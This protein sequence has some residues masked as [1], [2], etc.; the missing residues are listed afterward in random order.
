ML[1]SRDVRVSLDER[2]EDLHDHLHDALVAQRARLGRVRRFVQR[3]ALLAHTSV[4]GVPVQEPGHRVRVLADHALPAV[5][6]IVALSTPCIQAERRSLAYTQLLCG[7]D[8]LHA[9][10]QAHMTHQ[11]L[12]VSQLYAATQQAC[13]A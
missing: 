7:N 13:A 5:I 10:F 4:Q 1:L 8:H 3:R 2:S 12:P 6:I 11:L 9:Y